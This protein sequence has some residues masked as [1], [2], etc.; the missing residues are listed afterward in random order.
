MAKKVKKNVNEE[1]LVEI[2]EDEVE[3]VTSTSSDLEE[4]NEMILSDIPIEKFLKDPSLSKIT[5]DDEVEETTNWCPV[6]AEHTIFVDKVCTVCGFTKTSKKQ[7]VNNEDP[8]DASFEIQPNEDVVD[9]LIGY[10]A[11]DDSDEKDDI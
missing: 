5:D 7:D 6:C 10:E 8:E 1:D 4:Q 11:V 2:P 9:E 3:S